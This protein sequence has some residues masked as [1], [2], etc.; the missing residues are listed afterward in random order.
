[1]QVKMQLSVPAVVRK[2]GRWYVSSCPLLD[3]HSQGQSAEEAKR[4][5]VEALTE[6]LLSCFERGTLTQVLQEAG[7]VPAAEAAPRRA[8]RERGTTPITVPLP[9]VIQDRHRG[10]RTRLAT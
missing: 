6:F 5:L 2:R 9:F 4:N 1:M 7:F 10:G 3:V 8:P